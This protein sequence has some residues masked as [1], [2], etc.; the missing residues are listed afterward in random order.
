MRDQAL[1]TKRQYMNSLRHPLPTPD[2][3]KSPGSQSE[4]GQYFTNY[5]KQQLIDKYGTSRVFGGGLRVHT[6]RGRRSTSG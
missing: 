1:I 4:V 3:I 2:D 5:V 6:T